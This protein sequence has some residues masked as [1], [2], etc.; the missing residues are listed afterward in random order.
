MSSIQN[1]DKGCKHQN[2]ANQAG[3]DADN[4]EPVCRCGNIEGNNAKETHHPYA[5]NKGKGTSDIEKIP[6]RLHTMKI[7]NKL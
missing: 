7:G 3:N 1:K 4:N 2:I 5:D 6:I